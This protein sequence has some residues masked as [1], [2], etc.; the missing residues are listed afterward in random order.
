MEL[1]IFKIAR[2]RRCCLNVIVWR[3]DN[4]EYGPSQVQYIL[5]EK[6]HIYKSKGLFFSIFFT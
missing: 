3:H 4:D 1:G 5:S 6:C 2:N